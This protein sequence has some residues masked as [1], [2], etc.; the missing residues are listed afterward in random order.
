MMT[1]K[2][3]YRI[4]NNETDKYEGA[5]SRAAHTEYEFSSVRDAR[6]SNVN[7]IFKNKRQYRIQKWKVTYELIKD[8][9]DPWLIYPIPYM[10]EINLAIAMNKHWNDAIKKAFGGLGMAITHD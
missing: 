8:D 7:N 4:L 10:H 5:Y 9:V 1:E 3:I 6:S 2:I